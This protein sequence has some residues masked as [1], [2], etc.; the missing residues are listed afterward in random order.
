VLARWQQ[1]DPST[2]VLIRLLEVRP[3]AGRSS[4][5]GSGFGPSARKLLDHHFQ[6][7]GE[8]LTITGR[9]WGASRLFCTP[10]SLDRADLNHSI[11]PI[12]LFDALLVQPCYAK[13]DCR[14]FLV[15]I[16][17]AGQGRILRA[18]ALLV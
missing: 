2:G 4:L 12:G 15:A 8:D 3:G 17:D 1:R 11:C 9:E 14:R 7:D 13:L 5:S 10:E 16:L 6:A 18:E